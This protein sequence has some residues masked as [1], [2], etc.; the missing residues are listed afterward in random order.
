[1]AKYRSNRTREVE[2]LPS[3]TPEQDVKLLSQQIDKGKQLLKDG[4]VDSDRYSAWVTVTRDFLIKVF[5]SLSPN[6][7]SV[8]GVGIN[9]SFPINAGREWY[10]DHRVRSLNKQITIMEGLLE[11]LQTEIALDQGSGGG[12]TISIQMPP[13]AKSVFLVHGQD[14]SA[15]NITARFIERL[16][17]DLIILHEQPNQGRTIIEKFQ[18]YSDVAFA[19]VL[20]TPDD[21]GGLA[22]EPYESQSQRARQNVIFELGYFIGRLGRNRVCALYYEGV[23]LP[24]DYSGVLFIK[25]DESG[26]W[27]L[28]LAK[29]MKAAGIDIDMNKA[30]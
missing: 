11:V 6:V 7:S 8:T 20:L 4:Y 1:V 10:E 17:L 9:G 29:E 2:V 25:F 28:S 19:V 14:S 18:D 30:L 13:G 3:V 12:A 5:G 24:S 26:A 15:E 16:D 23:E 27:R 22:S 21:R